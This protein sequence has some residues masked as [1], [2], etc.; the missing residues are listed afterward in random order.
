MNSRRFWIAQSI[1]AWFVSSITA[2]AWLTSARAEH[3]HLL[4]T[5]V[6]LLAFCSGYGLC[7]RRNH[8]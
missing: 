2:H 3:P 6:L 4:I 7:E 8:K 1:V 5:G